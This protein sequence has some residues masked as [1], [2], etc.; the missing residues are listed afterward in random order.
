MF[1]AHDKEQGLPCRLPVAFKGSKGQ[2]T[3]STACYVLNRV[4]VTKPQNKTPYELLTG[5]FEENYDEGFLVRYSLC[6]KAFRPITKENKAN[7]TGVQKKLIIVQSSKAKNG[8]E[9]LNE[10]TNSK[11]NKEPLDQ[12]DQ[13]F[14]EE[15]ERL[16]RQAKEA[17]DADKTLRKT[18]PVNAASTPLNTASTSTNQDDYQIPSLE[19]IYE[20]SRDEIFT[21][22]SYDDKDA[23]ADFIILD[24]IVNH[25]LF[26]SFLSQIEPKK[27]S[28]DLEDESWVDAMQEELLQFKTHQVWIFVDLPFGKKVIGTKWVYINKKDERRV[29]VRNK[30]RLVAQGHRQEEGIDYDEV[31]AHV[32]RIEAIMIFLAFASYMGFIVYQMDVKSTLLYGKINKEVYVSQPLGFIDHKFPNKVYRVVKALY[33]LHQAPK[34]WYA[35]LSTFLVQNGYK[36]ALIDKTL[37][38]KKDKKDIMLDKYVAEIVKKFDFM[39]VKTAS[40]P[41]KTKKPLVKDAKAADVDVT[42]KTSHLHAVK[43]IFRRLISW[44][45]KKQTIVATSITE[46]EYFVAAS[47][48][49]QV[50][51]KT[52]N[53]EVRIQALVDG[54][55]VNI[56]ES[57]I[58][59]TL[60]LDDVKD[61]QNVPS[62]SNDLL[63]SGDDSLKLKEL[64][65]L[66]TNLSNKVPELESGVIDIKSTYQEKIKKLK[67][68]VERLEEENKVLKELKTVYSIDDADEAIMEKEKSSK[69]GMKLADI[70]AD[71]EINLE[72]AQVEAYNLDLDHQEKVLSMM[73]VNEE[74]P[75]D[76][77][78]VLEVVKAAKLMTE[79]VAIAGATKVNVP[80]KRKGVTI[81]D[82]VEKT[83]IATVEP[84]VQAKDKGKAILIEE[85]KPLK[86]QAQINLDEEVARQLEVELNVDINWNAIIEQVKRSERL[87]DAVM[88]YQTLKR[89]PL[90][91]AQAKRNMIVYLKNIAGFKMDYFKGMTYDEIK[92]LFEKHYNF[93]QAFLDEM[94]KKQKIEEETKELKKH[95]QIVTDDDDDV[96]TDATPLASKIPI[97]DYKI[98]TKRNKP[99][100]KI[101]RADKNHITSL[102]RFPAQSIR[103]SN[104]IALDSP[105][106]L[107]LITGTSQSRQHG[108]SESDSY[109]LSDLSR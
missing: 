76:V 100:F 71:V 62:H 73:D 85:P 37:F 68:N 102:I 92:P 60:R 21:S 72:K 57:S 22:A 19:D 84:K 66:C 91:Q 4:L 45:C 11:T 6:S 77:E 28:Q 43:R 12:E 55:R 67:G 29:V 89:K 7:K 35:T 9:K 82:P 107:V 69:Q 13:A 1:K 51:V 41:I 3:V 40:T 18:T 88:K 8:D 59:G 42:P 31:F 52:I 10:D 32:A 74:D 97:V 54:K 80:R 86:R 95:L 53:D 48:C 36:K 78:E 63:P 30:A 50:K 61:E 99:D 23:M 75:V 14:L 46:A 26:A 104:A 108:K 106:L 33:G 83:T 105:Y 79:V 38:I 49:G 90:T 87:H 2:I 20:V 94:A 17:N 64:M 39:S 81:Q 93:N 44:Q 25:C 15:L 103:S 24:S 5:K 56:K 96:Y 101:I 109:Y 65:D 27:I 47:C 70:D 16:K 34:A 58:R 98:H